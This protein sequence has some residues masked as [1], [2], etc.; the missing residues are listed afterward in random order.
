MVPK[1]NAIKKKL[2][3]TGS[4]TKREVILNIPYTYIVDRLPSESDSI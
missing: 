2:L 3:R 1:S 4:Q